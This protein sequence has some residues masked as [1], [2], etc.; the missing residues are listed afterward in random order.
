V[1]GQAPDLGLGVADGGGERELVAVAGREEQT[2]ELV[3]R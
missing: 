1:S 2:G 3:H